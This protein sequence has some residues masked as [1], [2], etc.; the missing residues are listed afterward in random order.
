MYFHSRA[1]AGEQLARELFDKYRYENVA[2]VALG[3]G[4]VAVGEPVAERLHCILT[5][6]VSENIDVPGEG[7]SFGA[8]SQTGKF[9][10]NSDLAASE[11]GEY[12]TEFH[13]YLEEQKQ[14][15]FHKIN[16]LIGDGG[17]IDQE[18][19]QGHTVVLISDGLNDITILDVAMDFLKPVRIQR[20]VIAAP[21]ASVEMVDK[22]HM[23][24]DELH[25]LDVKANY[26][27]TD[28]YYDQ[29]DLPTHEETIAK[30]N[31]IVLNWR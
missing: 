5:L 26:L 2:I 31:K 13:G 22:V 25:I 28:H 15:A 27:D 19:L 6:L 16:R 17:V 8:V 4:S 11:V 1:E 29:N 12:M 7:Q 14:Q 23:I 3:D 20:L 9:T 10:S 18:L 24:A 30:I 21:V